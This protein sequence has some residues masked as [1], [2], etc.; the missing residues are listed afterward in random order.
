MFLTQRPKSGAGDMLQLVY[1][2][3]EERWVEVS[4]RRKVAKELHGGVLTSF[5][6]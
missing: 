4:C 2:F 5:F 6:F 3:S 1:K